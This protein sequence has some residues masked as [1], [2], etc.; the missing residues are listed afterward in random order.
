MISDLLGGQL[1]LAMDF[2]PSYVPLVR[3][4]KIR[5]LA[6]TTAQRVSDLPDAKTVQESGSRI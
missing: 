2:M 3:D 6:V 4:G 5:A 1:D